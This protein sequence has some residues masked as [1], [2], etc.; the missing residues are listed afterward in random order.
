[1]FFEST[2]N[3]ANRTRTEYSARNTSIALVSRILI[4]IAGYITR[5]VFIHTL[6]EDYVGVNGLFTDIINVLSLSEMGLS[7]A[8]T[9]ALYK[10]IAEQN[11]EKI[12]SLMLFYKR[13]YTI[14]ALVVATIGLILMPFLNVLM[15][16]KPNVDNLYL[17]YLLYLAGS[18]TS[19]LFVYKK[20]LIDANQLSYIT[21][22]YYTL[23]YLI[24][25]IIQIVV[26]VLTHNFILFLL[27]NIVATFILNT[28]YS[29]KADRL[30]PYIKEKN[31]A[32]L[33]KEEHI[34][35]RNNIGAM[36]LHK[37]G[38]VV[39]DNTDNL[40]M[41]AFIGVIE[42][43]IYSNYFLIITSIRHMFNQFFDALTA[44]VGNLAV[45]SDGKTVKKIFEGTNFI[46]QWIF[47]LVSVV[48]YET[49]NPFV[50]LSFGKTYLFGKDI[51][52]ILCINF[53]V[54]G[55]CQPTLVFRDS[56]GLFW[57]DRY[58]SIVEAIINIVVSIILVNKIGLVGIFVGTLISTLTT[59]F[60]VEPFVFYRHIK[61]SSMRFF[62]KMGQYILVWAILWYGTD[63]LCSFATQN[64]GCGLVLTI[65][66]NFVICM[67]VINPILLLLYF[68]TPEFETLKEKAKL[69]IAKL[70][71]RRH[72]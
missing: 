13:M 39:V 1:M 5:I 63:K 9:F 59:T 66:V 6:S 24:Q 29:S 36:F 51:V 25:D 41:S 33:S 34:S 30:Y 50:E 54:R 23:V 8:V 45:L 35:M 65:V 10:P 53:F 68:R 32:P 47:G 43:G 69:L 19:Y 27:L 28:M 52:L 46:G 62:L 3:D 18:V 20:T 56:I 16:N 57:V 49:I 38:N 40:I 67:V 55:L 22:I 71:A 7:T 4:I 48:I 64:L 26:L 60:W 11:R 70:S 21:S 15:K 37:F 42:V 58:K 31:S 44:S 14:V 12:K 61:E 2:N 17:I 72:S